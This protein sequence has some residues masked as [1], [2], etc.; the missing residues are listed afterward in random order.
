[1][2]KELLELI[3]RTTSSLPPD[4]EAALR[5]ARAAEAPASQADLCLKVL[6]DNCA[7]ARSRACPMCQDTGMLSFFFTVPPGTDTAALTRDVREAVRAATTQGLL[8]QNTIDTLTGRSIADNVTPDAPIC[9]F[10]ERETAD[11]VEVR[12][13]QKGGGSENMSAQFS[14][15]DS[16]LQ[17]GRDLAGV[18]ACVLQAVQKAQGFGCAPG[19]LGVCIGGDRATG[20]IQ[21]KRQLLRPLNDTN[22]VPALADFETRVLADANTLG[23]GP[24]GLGGKTT[25]LGLK[26]ASAARLPASYF[27]TIAYCCW[28]CRRGGLRYRKG[29]Y[30]YF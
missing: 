27:V 14:L 8:R 19:I 4:I 3:Q 12:L 22:P 1:M 29:T 25:L 24:M 28:A 15:P 2:S 20:F 16:S 5:A 7:L 6:L 23:I 11:A 9:Y 30:E 26:A 18:R 10:D 17:A 21:A 13:L